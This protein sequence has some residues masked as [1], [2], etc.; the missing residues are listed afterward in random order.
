L[1]FSSIKVTAVPELEVAV[2]VKPKGDPEHIEATVETAVKA[3]GIGLTTKVLEAVAT[4]QEPPDEV[5]VS[6]AVPE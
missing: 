5:S 2:E 3:V 1:K 6:V 4:P